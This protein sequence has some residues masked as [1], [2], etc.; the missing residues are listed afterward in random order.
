VVLVTG[1]YPDRDLEELAARYRL[2]KLWEAQDP[3]ALVAEHGADVR[4]IA[5]RGDL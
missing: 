3:A 1:P 5:T 2:L 4:A